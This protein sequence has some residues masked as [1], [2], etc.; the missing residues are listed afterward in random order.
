MRERDGEMLKQQTEETEKEPGKEVEK[1]KEW[2]GFLEREKG[3]F[4]KR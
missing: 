4:E 2:V 3:K 1:E